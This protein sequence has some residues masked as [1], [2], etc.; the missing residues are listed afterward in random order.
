M[1]AISIQE[2]EKVY[3]CLI[4]SYAIEAVSER[5]CN[6]IHNHPLH[7]ATEKIKSK[8]NIKHKMANMSFFKAF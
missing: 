1:Q 5:W 3:F 2:E 7:K 4:L 8:P 6:V